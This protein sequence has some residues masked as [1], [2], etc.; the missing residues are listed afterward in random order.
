MSLHNVKKL[1]LHRFNFEDEAI[2]KRTA[3]NKICN[4]Y[5]KKKIRK[6]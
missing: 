3:T 6:T 1:Y 2:E 4:S 5:T